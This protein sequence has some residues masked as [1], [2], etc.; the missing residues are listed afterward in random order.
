MGRLSEIDMAY[1]AYWTL[2]KEL[3]AEFEAK[4]AEAGFHGEPSEGTRERLA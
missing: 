4:M 3:L 1:V 2:S